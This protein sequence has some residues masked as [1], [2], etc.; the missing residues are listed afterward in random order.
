MPRHWPLNRELR[1]CCWKALTPVV[2]NWFQCLGNGCR[3]VIFK[4][5]LESHKFLYHRVVI[6]QRLGHLRAFCITELSETKLDL[7]ATGIDVFKIIGRRGLDLETRLI[8]C[9]SNGQKTNCCDFLG[10]TW[11]LIARIME[12]VYGKEW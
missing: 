10:A 3:T 12:I 11:V 6:H 1:C 2:S 8:L 4:L 9:W 5:L 7:R